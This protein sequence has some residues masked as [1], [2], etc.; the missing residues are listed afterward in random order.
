MIYTWAFNDDCCMAENMPLVHNCHLIIKWC[1]QKLFR[2]IFSLFIIY[3]QYE[4]VYIKYL[5]MFLSH[6]TMGKYI[7]Y[8]LVLISVQKFYAKSKPDCDLVTRLWFSYT[9]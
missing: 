5:S 6:N 2:I 9:G 1:Y 8:L 4:T 7:D 3:N